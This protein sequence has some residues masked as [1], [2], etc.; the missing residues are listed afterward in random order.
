[1]DKIVPRI[2]QKTREKSWKRLKRIGVKK[3]IALGE[4][5]EIEHINI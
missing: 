2:D 3:I 1:M 4:E 5:G